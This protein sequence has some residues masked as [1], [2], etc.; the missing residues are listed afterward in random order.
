[1]RPGEPNAG[2]GFLPGV[3]VAGG[4]P[5]LPLTPTG[6]NPSLG[7]YGHYVPTAATANLS[8][9]PTAV[10]AAA[11]NGLATVETAG[12]RYAVDADFLQ[13][14]SA[15]STGLPPGV[16]LPPAPLPPAPAAAGSATHLCATCHARLPPGVW[17]RD[18]TAQCDQCTN[19][20]KMNGIRG[21][22]SSATSGGGG[23]QSGGRSSGGSKRVSSSV[24]PLRKDSIEVS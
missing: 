5:P 2:D 3:G 1:M 14:A 17:R 10:A 24:G 18:G 16:S 4:G 21:V 15:T 11:G 9:Y 6:K 22:S 8:S 23:G 13:Q 20:S 19:Y 12:V 7:H